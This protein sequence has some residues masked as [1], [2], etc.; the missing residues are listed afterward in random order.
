ML[1]SLCASETDTP[2]LNV[3]WMWRLMA[4][5]PLRGY[6]KIPGSESEAPQGAG[7]TAQVHGRLFALAGAGGILI[8]LP[9]RGG[10]G[11]QASKL[12]QMWGWCLRRHGAQIFQ[13]RQV[14]SQTMYQA[15]NC[16]EWHP[17]RRQLRRDP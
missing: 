12:A 17:G 7:K 6:E 14:Q 4:P 2:T 13:S 10:Q 3:V 11:A 16:N 5:H 8:S 9:R 15:V 1:W